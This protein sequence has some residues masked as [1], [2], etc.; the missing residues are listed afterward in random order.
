MKLSGML[1]ILILASCSSMDI[2]SQKVFSCPASPYPLEILQND[3]TKISVLGKGSEHMHYTT[4]LDNYIL[5]KNKEGLFEYATLDKDMLLAPSGVRASNKENRK[6]TELEFLDTLDRES[7]IKSAVKEQQKANVIVT[8]GA[9]NDL[10]TSKSFPREGE[11][12]VLLLLIK[13][14]D[15]DN[16]YTKTEFHNLMNEKNYGGYG[17]FKDYYSEV[18]RGKLNITTD[19]YGWYVAANNHEYYGE[20]SGDDVARELVQEA[21]DAAEASGVDFS[22]YDN[23]QDGYVDGVTV[24]HSG[25]G[26]ESGGLTEYIWSHRSSLGSAFQ[27]NY[28]GVIVNSYNIC[29]ETRS[30]GMVGIGVLCHEFGHILGLPDLYDIDESDGDSE[31]IGNW[32]LMAGGPW[33]NSERSPANMCAWSRMTLGWITPVQIRNGSFSLEPASESGAVYRIYT[34]AAKEYFLLE[35]RQNVGQDEYLPG[36]GLAIYHIDDNLTVNSDE[37]HKLVDLEEADGLDQLDKSVNRGDEGDLYPGSTNAVA[38]DASSYPNSDLYSGMTS[39]ISI[40]DISEDQMTVSFTLSTSPDPRDNLISINGC[41]PDNLQTYTGN[42]SGAWFTSDLNACGT[43]S[44]GSES[45]YSFTAPVTGNYSI[46]VVSATGNVNYLAG[47]AIDSVGWECIDAIN[48]TG[49]FGSFRWIADSTYY[50]LLDAATT[51]S[52]AHNFYINCPSIELEYYSHEIDDDNSTSI[53]DDDGL[54]EGGESIE[55]P[56]TIINT[57]SGDA[58]AVW[59]ILSTADENITISDEDLYFDTIRANSTVRM[60]D[61]DFDIAIDCPDKDVTFNLEIYSDQGIWLTEFIVHIYPVDNPDKLPFKAIYPDPVDGITGISV[62]TESLSWQNGGGALSYALYYGN[63]PDPGV[64]E[65]QFETAY[66]SVT[67]NGLDYNTT[68][69]WR[70]DAINNIGTTTGD[71]WS[72]TTEADPLTLPEKPVNPVPGNGSSDLSIAPQ[73]LSWTNGG[74]ATSYTV[75]IGLDTSLGEEDFLGNQSDTTFTTSTLNYSTNYYWRVDATNEYG[76]TEGDIWSFTTEAEPLS[77]PSKPMNPD[78]VDGSLDISVNTLQLS[79]SDGGGATSYNVYM[80]MTSALD[81][82]DSL[83]NQFVTSYVPESLDYSTTY[84]WR[85]DALNLAGITAGDVW[86][87]TTEAEPPPLPAKAISPVPENGSNEISVNIGE[88]NWSDGGGA[89]SYDV[90]FGTEAILDSLD[91]Q[92]NTEEL[93]VALTVLDYDLTYFWRIDAVNETGTTTGDVWSFSVEKETGI[94]PFRNPEGLKIYPN[95]AENYI[96][97]EGKGSDKVLT[98]TIT[99]I[100]GRELYRNKL[101]G[102]IQKRMIDVSFLQSGTY[103]LKITGEK[104]I[105]TQ[106]IEIK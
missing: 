26:G 37:K 61:F 73:Q 97:L 60:F 59:A 84:F 10:N 83:L 74:H 46:E 87:F 96:I 98:Y 22:I 78:P 6:A 41:G 80:G 76:T 11:R 15:I 68:Y 8:K 62:F 40:S 103:I 71:V 35:N 47:T 64:D 32:G 66:S 99:D 21:I 27:R 38:F 82:Q 91:F 4:T 69:Y 24:V 23:D 20:D 30:W 92:F 67:L 54:P 57:G 63:N 55:M 39:G 31:G 50:L 43:M 9:S 2:H 58:T 94:S 7:I 88:L 44:P 13:Y 12:R 72:F 28:D 102:S 25:P 104:Y 101:D 105:S 89:A 36:E 16:S 19:V 93:S 106:K 33:L 70:I 75:Y 77:P 79:W 3:G 18:S 65:F 14:Q 42:G 100:S 51:D 48:S 53:G 17:S 29:P 52:S 81:E 49:T 56:L 85:I 90:Y 86:T 34:A 95:P 45:I 5:V 1:A